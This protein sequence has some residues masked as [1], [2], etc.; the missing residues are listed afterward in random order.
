MEKEK[1]RITFVKVDFL[2]ASEYNPRKWDDAA[3]Q[4][5]KESIKKYGLVDPLIANSAP[6]RKNILIGGHFRLITAKR[7]GIQEVPVVY[8]NIPDIEKEK[9]LNL[10]LNKNTGEFDWNLLANFDESFLSSIGFSSE[11]LDEI[12]AME[13]EPEIFDLKK[14]LEKLNIKKIEIQKGDVWQLGENRLMCGDST[15]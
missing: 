10:R 8:L 4:Q 1:L 6:Q 13:D 14:E 7:L 5:L 11:E 12:F 15:I 3:A 2:K 9:E